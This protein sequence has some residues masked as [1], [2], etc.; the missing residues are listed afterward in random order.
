MAGPFIVDMLGTMTIDGDTLTGV[1]LTGEQDATKAAGSYFGEPV[2]LHPAGTAAELAKLGAWVAKN[3]ADVDNAVAD[4]TRELQQQVAA[5]GD[6]IDELEAE[7]QADRETIADLRNLLKA[8]ADSEGT[9]ISLIEE[10]AISLIEEAFA[11]GL[12]AGRSE[13]AEHNAEIWRR[14]I[15][16]AAMRVEQAT[17]DW[18]CQPNAGEISAAIRALPMPADLGGKNG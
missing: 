13:M 5:Y 18:F 17:D 8:R 12:R 14:A 1:F 3:G 10:A 16:A 6:R 15:E 9:A 4:R 2:E 11:L 7:A